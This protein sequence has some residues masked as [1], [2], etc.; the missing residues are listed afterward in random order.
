M[1]KK[2]CFVVIY[3]IESVL[4]HESCLHFLLRVAFK[5]RLSVY[6]TNSATRAW[7][8]ELL[9]AKIFI[10]LPNYQKIPLFCGDKILTE[11]R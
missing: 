1:L 8:N 11:K 3:C 9:N 6:L 5:I 10:F 2:A 4:G 7:C